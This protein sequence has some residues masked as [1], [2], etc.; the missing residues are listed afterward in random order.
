MDRPVTPTP[1]LRG[2]AAAGLLLSHLERG[3][4][5]DATILARQIIHTHAETGA[6]TELL[7]IRERRRSEPVTMPQ[8]LDLGRERESGY[9]RNTQS[10]RVAVRIPAPGLVTEEGEYERRVRLVRPMETQLHSVDAFSASHW[11]PIDQETF[12]PLWEA[13]LRTVDEFVE[14]EF[15]MV[16]GLLLPVWKRLPT[17]HARVYRLQTDQGERVLGRRVPAAWAANAGAT[18]SPALSGSDARA[19]LLDGG[20]VLHLAE[21]MQVR[22]VRVMGRMRI[23]L[24]GFTEGMRERLRAY[25][26]FSE[27]ISWSLR[28]FVPVDEVGDMV[29]ERMFETWPIERVTEKEAA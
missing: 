1:D 7:T 12:V 27:I 22:R 29:L 24:T 6:D 19:A 20:T 14:A 15:H 23:E 21:R 9:V 8:A 16:T 5:L 28:F 10:G 4:T 2:F 18:G 17:D 3:E 13:E 26:L 11:K 25:G